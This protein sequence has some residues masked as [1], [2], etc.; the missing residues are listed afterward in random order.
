V[1]YVPLL[2]DVPAGTVVASIE[3]HDSLS[4]TGVKVKLS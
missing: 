1:N 3:L 2:F 4:S